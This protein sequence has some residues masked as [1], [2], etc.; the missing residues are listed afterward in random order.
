MLFIF[1]PDLIDQSFRAYFEF[2]EKNTNYVSAYQEAVGT[3]F[4]SI[5]KEA[6]TYFDAALARDRAIE[7]SEHAYRVPLRN[8][9]LA[10]DYVTI[11]TDGQA[12]QLYRAYGQPGG[13]SNLF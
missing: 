7:S 8:L 3:S 12:V 5:G 6:G 2:L 1:S 10:K 4:I 9:I 11:L 13:S